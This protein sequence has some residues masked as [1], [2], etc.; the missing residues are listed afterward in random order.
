[1]PRRAWMLFVGLCFLPAT[2]VAGGAIVDVTVGP[3]FTFS[4]DPVTI[5]AGDTVR[6]TQA[7]GFHNVQ[8]D[9]DSWGNK[10]A[11]GNWVFTHTFT[12]A[13]VGPNPY[14]CIVHSTPG[15]TTM[16]GVV[17][18]SAPPAMSVDDTLV[19]DG[20]LGT[21]RAFFYIRLSTAGTET[22]SASYATGDGTATTP[23]DYAS[24]SGTVTFPPGSVLQIVEVP[25]VNDVAAEGGETFVLNLSAPVGA[26]LGDAQGVATIRDGRSPKGDFNSD[27][28]VDILWRHQ[29]SGQNVAWFM[30]GLTLL[31]GRFTDP[32]A[33]ADVSWNIVGASDFND[34]GLTDLLWRNQVSGENVLWFMNGVTLVN[35]AFTNPAALADVRWKAV[36]TGDFNLDSRPDILWRHDVAGE[37]VAWFM[38]GPTLVSGTFL[39][40]SSLA[41]VRWKMA[42]TGDF[43]LDGKVDILWRHS[44]AGELVVWFMNGTV[45]DRGTFLSPPSLAD[46]GWQIGGTGDYNADGN[47]DIVWRHGV[48]GQ[49][50]FW[51]MDGTTLID[52]ALINTLADTGWQMVGPR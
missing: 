44:T 37:N 9:D 21:T 38:N 26:T 39:T 34:N 22:A 20:N 19:T 45:L 8:A 25:V 6:W 18:V 50:V 14:Y 2:A 10:P 43:D 32:P 41:D 47:V 23:G 4:P 7:G 48:S 5:N 49:N 51:F 31:T 11:T 33:F 27:T 52:G 30:D 40:P 36:G 15:G 13:D 42:G 16:N 28:R 17:N 35:G 29:G 12:V 3:G 1:M 24:T 46:T